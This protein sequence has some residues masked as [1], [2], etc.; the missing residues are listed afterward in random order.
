[1]IK[2]GGRLTSIDRS[3]GDKDSHSDRRLQRLRAALL[4]LVDLGPHA[5]ASA[6]TRCAHVFFVL[7][8]TGFRR[9]CRN[10]AH[11]P[12]WDDHQNSTRSLLPRGET[13]EHMVIPRVS[14]LLI[15]A[16]AHMS[17]GPLAM[18]ETRGHFRCPHMATRSEKHEKGLITP[19]RSPCGTSMPNAPTEMLGMCG[20]GNA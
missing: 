20:H 6:R 8:G 14:L 19:G 3:E 13:E 18:C 12:T 11:G 2:Y 17:L 1:M 5:W 15:P 4:P 16:C 9:L 7:H 10:L